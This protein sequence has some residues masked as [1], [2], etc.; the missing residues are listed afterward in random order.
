MFL[1]M[2][3]EHLY[4]FDAEQE[5]LE[6]FECFDEND[7]GVVRGDEMRRWLADVGEKMDQAEV[8][9]CLGSFFVSQWT[10]LMMVW[11]GGRLINC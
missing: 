8:S 2:M 9:R 4:E 10:V 7:A 6:A 5:L 11:V 1:T 3:G